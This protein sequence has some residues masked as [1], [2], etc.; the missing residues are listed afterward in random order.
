MR[1]GDRSLCNKQ[2]P[3]PVGS[4]LI[5]KAQANANLKTRAIT[6]TSSKIDD[7]AVHDH[8]DTAVVFALQTQQLT[9]GGN[10]ISG[11]F[12]STDTFVKR[13]GR[14]QCVATQVTRVSQGPQ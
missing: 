3:D 10:E 14:W 13:D 7:I 5:P 8:G 6:F 4:T 2:R 1:C 11:Q 12:R 9:L